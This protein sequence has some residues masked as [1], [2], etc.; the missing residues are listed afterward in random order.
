LLLGADEQDRAA[1]MGDLGRERLRL[2][3]QR[4]RLQKVD[5]VDAAALAMDEAAHLR[6]PAARL[7][8]E[9]DSGFQQLL[10]ADLGHGDFSLCGLCRSPGHRGWRG[11]GVSRRAGTA[12]LGEVS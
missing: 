4:L 12:P 3:E 8:A 11:P 5:Q 10:E 2:V 6:V 7:M 9:V 1:A